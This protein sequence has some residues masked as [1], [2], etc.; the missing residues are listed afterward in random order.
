M[1]IRV[2]PFTV[3]DFVHVY[4]RGNRKMIVFRDINDKW[5]FLKI[6]RFF[7]DEYSPANS[8]RQLEWSVGGN[9]GVRPQQLPSG[10]FKW[11]EWPKDWPSH[12][13]LVKILSYCLKN[14]HFHLLLKEITA[15]GISKFMRKLGDGFTVYSNLKYDEVGRVFQGSY[16]GR[17]VMK[18]IKILQYLDA[19]IQIFNP[20]EDYPG[21][22]E[23]ALKEFDQAFEFAMNSPFCSLGESFG[24]RNLKIIDRDILKEMFPNKEMYKKFAYDALLVRNTREIL[25]KLTMD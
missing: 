14:N 6:L 3:D 25:G 11:P 19:Y 16:R 8:F 13:P 22:I 9:V 5:R 17:T 2:E 12:K 10:E 15:G 18:D 4:N 7:N 21:G 24:K 20:F 1:K 23:K